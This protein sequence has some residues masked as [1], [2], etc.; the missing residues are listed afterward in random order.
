MV[1]SRTHQRRVVWFG[2][3]ARSHV[4]WQ[5][6]TRRSSCM[7]SKQEAVILWRHGWHELSWRPSQGTPYIRYNIRP[8]RGTPSLL[9]L[10][11]YFSFLQPGRTYPSECLLVTPSR[12]GNKVVPYFCRTRLERMSSI[13]I[14]HGT[15]KRQDPTWTPPRSY[16]KVKERK[17]L[18]TKNKKGRN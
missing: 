17:I 15:Y 4:A 14:Q 1:G 13:Q 5:R 7:T 11:P 6:G 9:T 12:L 16:Y 10:A 2:H 3:V 18:T 8:K